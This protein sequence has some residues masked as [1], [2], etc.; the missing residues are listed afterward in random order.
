MVKKVEISKNIPL[1]YIIGSLMWGRFFIP[2]LALFYIASRVTLEQF[3]LI[4][5]VFSLSILLLEIPSGVIA[6]ILGKK[7]TLL[8]SRF[9]YIVEIFMIAFFD[10]FWIFL[11]AKIV[12]GMGISLSSGTGSALLYDTLKKMGREDEHKKISGKL[13]T[14]TNVS[15]AFVFII[16]AY[17]FS[18]NYKLPAIVSL[19]FIIMGF[20][21]TFFLKEPYK[22]GKNLT[23]KNSWNHLKEG[24]LFF[25]NSKY[26]KFITFFSLFVLST[27]SIILSLSSVYFEQILIPISLIGVISFIAS[28]ITAYSSKKAHK[29]Y[30]YLGDKRSFVF[31]GII[32][33][34]GIFLVSLL[35]PYYG[36]FAYL[37]IPLVSGFLVVI[38]SDYTNKHINSSHR[39]TL[40]SIKNFF[41]SFGIFLLFPFIGKLIGLKSMDF[42]F[43]IFGII[44][45]IGLIF[46]WIISRKFK[47]KLD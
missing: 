11:V 33:V 9:M 25:K 39:A 13:S 22:S 43:K 7:K 2:V 21:L 6:D 3:T 36:I 15:M 14:I 5:G 28:M 42:A 24:L 47:L 1:I 26:V 27:I 35:I 31:A 38:I 19:P 10:G 17:L 40:I 29:L 30:D 44:I 37:L 4:I 34:L 41:V 32:I 16:G 45:F 12:S 18:L 8:I 46:V 23:I 20:I